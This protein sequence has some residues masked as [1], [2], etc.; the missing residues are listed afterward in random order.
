MLV[1]IGIAIE[2]PHGTYG[3]IATRS[4]LATRG[5]EIGGGGGGGIDRGYRGEIRV[6]VH[7]LSPMEFWVRSGD[8]IAQMIVEKVLEV[9]VRQVDS[10]SATARHIGGF[11]STNCGDAARG[12][13]SFSVKK[14]GPVHPRTEA[15]EG[16]NDHSTS[17]AIRGETIYELYDHE[18]YLALDGGDAT[19]E[20]YVLVECDPKDPGRKEQSG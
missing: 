11:G 13:T 4:S 3:R 15:Q 7:N 16:G 5:I 17:F 2:L 19:A 18:A 10:L 6:L 9:P 14:L 1:R 8:R 12:I 20:L